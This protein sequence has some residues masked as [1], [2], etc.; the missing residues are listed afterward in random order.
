MDLTGPIILAGQA[1]QPRL[2]GVTVTSGNVT[3]IR[4]SNNNSDWRSKFGRLS[5]S[6]FVAKSYGGRSS[7]NAMTGVLPPFDMADGFP[8][9]QTLDLSRNQFTG[10]YPVANRDDAQRSL[11]I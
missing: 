11:A 4:L 10:N 2:V 8:V 9:L 6:G 5:C 3:E 7:D 1:K